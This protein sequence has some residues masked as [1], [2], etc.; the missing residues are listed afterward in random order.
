MH[1]NTSKRM[2]VAKRTMHLSE[3]DLQELD[4]EIRENISRIR[5]EQDFS[6]SDLSEITGISESYLHQIMTGHAKNFGLRHVYKIMI[7]LDIKPE[8][9]FPKRLLKRQE[10]EEYGEQFEYLVKDMSKKQ[11]QFLMGVVEM[12][13]DSIGQETPENADRKEK[14]QNG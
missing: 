12:Y 5:C 6:Y 4:M 3:Y 1:Q 8:D 13:A 14:S 10:K 11:V 7:A 9:I 2:E